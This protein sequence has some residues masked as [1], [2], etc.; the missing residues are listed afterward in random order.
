[1]KKI[2]QLLFAALLFS[3]I[4]ATAQNF[5]IF[6]RSKCYF[7]QQ[8]SIVFGVKSDSVEILAVGDTVCHFFTMFWEE[9]FNTQ[10]CLDLYGGTLFGKKA[11]LTTDSSLILITKT[12]DSVILKPKAA[13]GDSWIA[14]RWPNQDLMIKATV[15]SQGPQNVLGAMD[16]VKSIVLSVQDGANQ[17]VASDPFNGKVLELSQNYGLLNIFDFYHFP[18]DTSLYSLVEVTPVADYRKSVVKR[19]FDFNVGDEFHTD[20]RNFNYLGYQMLNG[21]EEQ[22]MKRVISKTT[23]TPDTAITYSFERCAVTK[24]YLDSQI[25]TTHTYDTISVTYSY[26]NF[27]NSALFQMPFQ[28]FPVANGWYNNK[29]NHQSLSNNQRTYAYPD[30]VDVMFSDTCWR[31]IC[32]DP[33]PGVTTY[34]EGLGGPYYENLG[35]WGVPSNSH[36]LVYYQKGE[37]TWGTP[38]APNCL[39]LIND[40]QELKSSESVVNVYPNPAMNKVFVDLQNFDSGNVTLELFSMEGRLL[41][42]QSVVPNSV[43]EI[44]LQSLS[45]GMFVLKIRDKNHSVVRLMNKM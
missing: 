38:I 9:P 8:N 11:I 26:Q 27:A 30:R 41:L 6:E 4:A 35:G 32:A 22:L 33:G 15:S 1:M 13:V 3:T 12:S 17:V 7:F 43:S 14:Y 19:I 29:I 23:Y 24:I 10:N 45:S 16:E 2:N 37:T 21:Q 39:S 31:Y 44:D 36:K 34:M 40:V 20:Y 28:T 5:S 25:T 18:N 42:E